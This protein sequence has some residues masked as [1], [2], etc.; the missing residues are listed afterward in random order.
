MAMDGW[1]DAKN[2]PTLGYGV[3]AEEKSWL[4][5]LHDTIGEAHNI[6]NMVPDA[7]EEI[8]Y[9]R[10]RYE[11]KVCTVVV[12]NASNMVG[13]RRDLTEQQYEE[14]ECAIDELRHI[15]EQIEKGHKER[16]VQERDCLLV[17]AYGCNAHLLYLCGQDIIDATTIAHVV[18]A[19]KN[20]RNVH[21]SKSWLLD[22]H[23]GG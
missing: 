11:A 2:D 8:K 6:S 15:T 21:A 20:F 23:W 10:H 4:Y 1:S 3:T 5:D 17:D 22:G 19:A 18:T 7:K 16:R 9:L 14:L 13:M 12:D